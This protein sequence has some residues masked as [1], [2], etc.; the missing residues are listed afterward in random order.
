[1]GQIRQHFVEPPIGLGRHIGAL[2]PGEVTASDSGDLAWILW[3]GRVR[4]RPGHG[5]G[6]ERGNGQRAAMHCDLP[7]P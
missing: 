4:L 2:V 5:P 1:M 7:G 6:R 3:T